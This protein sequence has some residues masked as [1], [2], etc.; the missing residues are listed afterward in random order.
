MKRYDVQRSTVSN[1]MTLVV[2]ETH[3]ETTLQ[4]YDA[5]KYIMLYRMQYAA[6]RYIFA[7]SKFL[8]FLHVKISLIHF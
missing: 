5:H 3:T 1:R 4:T 2:P 6:K 7:R 8:Q